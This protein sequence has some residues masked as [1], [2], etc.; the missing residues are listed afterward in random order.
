LVEDQLGGRSP[1]SVIAPDERMKWTGGT[2]H[3]SVGRHGNG[4]PKIIEF[5]D[6]PVAVNLE[7]RW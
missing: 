7:P 6:N 3:F 2:R 4:A 1:A 5:N